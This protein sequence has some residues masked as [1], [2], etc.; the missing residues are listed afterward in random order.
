MRGFGDLNLILPLKGR[1]RGGRGGR[2]RAG[3]VHFRFD[4]LS[5]P[6]N[7]EGG[8]EGK[9]RGGGEKKKKKGA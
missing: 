3:A 9:K 2:R 1:G 8:G 4:Q 6:S 7:Q 5:H